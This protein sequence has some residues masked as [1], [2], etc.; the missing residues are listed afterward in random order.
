MSQ[1]L[2]RMAEPPAPSAYAIQ[3]DF[4]A[5]S[6]PA[7]LQF[8]QTVSISRD[9]PQAQAVFGAFYARYARYVT[10]MV[11]KRSFPA[12]SPADTEE[13]VAD[14]FLRFFDSCVRFDPGD[15]DSGAC[16]LKL[17]AYLG[18]AASRLSLDRFRASRNRIIEIPTDVPGL[19]NF[20]EPSA[21]ERDTDT[22]PPPSHAVI[23]A[24]MDTLRPLERD[25]LRTY[26]LD[27]HLGQKSSRLPDGVAE[28]LATRYGTTP[29]NLRQI[30]R[31]L[32][33]QLRTL[34]PA[35]ASP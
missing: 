16:D 32:L 5:L 18:T 31:K 7:L 13:I 3:P 14:T 27:D 29:E 12:P 23:A 22:P 2:P 1:P 4:A 15:C 35:D 17:K 28:A 10:Y 19:S 30:K 11:A 9:H 6:A 26:F 21:D 8:L 33:R 25:V 20:A 34:F 24:W